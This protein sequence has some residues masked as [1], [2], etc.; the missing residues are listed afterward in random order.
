MENEQCSEVTPTNYVKHFT[1]S[2]VYAHIFGYIKVSETF[3][4]L[5][6]SHLPSAPEP[7]LAKNDAVAPQNE[8]EVNS[9][10]DKNCATEITPLIHSLPSAPCYIKIEA[11]NLGNL[12]HLSV[13]TLKPLLAATKLGAF[14]GKRVIPTELSSQHINYDTSWEV[15]QNGLLLFII[16]GEHETTNWLKFIA[17]ARNPSEQN[18]DVYHNNEADELVFVTKREIGV[19]EELL[20]WYNLLDWTSCL[21]PNK[22]FPPIEQLSISKSSPS[23]CLSN[24][25]A[26]A[27]ENQTL[28]TQGEHTCEKCGSVFN[29]PYYLAR[30]KKY[31]ACADNPQRTFI[32]HICNR[33]FEKSE[34]LRVHIRQVH[35]KIKPYKCLTC[36]KDFS[37]S[38]SLTKHARIHNGYRPY[39][40][41]VCRK[42]FTASSILTTHMRQHTGERPFKCAICKKGFASHA[43]HH[44]HVRRTHGVEPRDVKIQNKAAFTN[45]KPTH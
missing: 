21:L 38:S 19:N 16:D 29:Y 26:I 45:D 18:I 37:Q 41:K 43:A 31:T 23:Q 25:I 8:S 14:T 42:E 5:S 15:Y 35:D 20:A 27:D 10:V 12:S 24:Y 39:K 13:T 6:N 44:S 11:F 28:Y 40:C 36:G 4:P 9:S 33:T 34:R 32:C 7:N 1:A 2:E 22:F 3:V 30:H 17:R